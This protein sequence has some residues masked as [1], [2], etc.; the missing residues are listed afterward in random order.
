MRKKGK[1]KKDQ[2]QEEKKTK[3]QRGALNSRD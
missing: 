2:R 1:E 3:D